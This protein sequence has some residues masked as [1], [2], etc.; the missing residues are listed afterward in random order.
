MVEKS[1]ALA[2]QLVLVPAFWLLCPALVDST[3]IFCLRCPKDSGFLQKI[4]LQV[5]WLKRPAQDL[6]KSYLTHMD[7][8]NDLRP[9]CKLPVAWLPSRNITKKPE[10]IMLQELYKA[11]VIMEDALKALEIRHTDAPMPLRHQLAAVSLS[12]TGL[13]S[14]IQC[15]HCLRGLHLVPITP[16]ERTQDSSSFVQKMEGCQVLWNLSKFIRSLAKAFQK[17]SVKGKKRRRLRHIAP[18]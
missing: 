17:P 3:S 5:T 7:L 12:L 18:F 15:A 13:L 10:R 8:Q 16:P 9:F 11:A 6:Y 1:L 14:N 2:A 4:H